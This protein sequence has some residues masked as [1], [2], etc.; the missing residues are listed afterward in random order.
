MSKSAHPLSLSLA[1][2]SV[3]TTI[4]QVAAVSGT[5]I[6]Y[7]Y[8]TLSGNQP[9]TYGDTL[10]LWQNQAQIPYNEPPTSSYTI[11]G[12][13]QAG[14]YTWNQL[15]I[16]TN[17]YIVGYAV[18]TDVKNICAWAFV[19]ASGS[20]DNSSSFATS[21]SVGAITSNSV[22]INFSTPAGNDP[23]ANGDWI[24]VWNNGA[25]SYIV[26]P[27]AKSGVKDLG[28]NNN[29]TVGINLALLRGNTY[30]VAYFKGGASTS[31]LTTMAATT[32]FST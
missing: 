25:P 6:T 11:P 9:N 30:A 4:I 32:T 8:N 17:S 22:V 7:S 23:T 21:I 24:G 27:T 3:S 14:G 13:T 31:T 2:A 20:A 26:Q 12:N 28:G 10:F 19:P 15:S 29:G 1:A 18:G 5:S 16:G